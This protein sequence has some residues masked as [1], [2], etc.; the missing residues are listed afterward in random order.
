MI[1]NKMKYTMLILAAAV[2]FSCAD[3]NNDDP[4]RKTNAGYVAF[5]Y[6]SR[7][8]RNYASL[9]MQLDHFN[10]YL[11]QPTLTQRDSVDRLY[12]RDA[13]ILSD[14]DENK[15]RIISINT[16]AANPVIVIS[17]NGKSLNEQGCVWTISDFDGY[18]NLS[19][20]FEFDVENVGNGMWHISKHDNTSYDSFEYTAEWTVGMTGNGYVLEGS[21]TLLSL[22]SPKLRLDYLITEPVDVKKDGNGTVSSVS[23]KVRIHATDVDKLLTE[24]STVR[25]FSNDEIEVTYM[26]HTETWRYT[27]F[28]FF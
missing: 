2:A 25:I 6:A 15:W 3:G 18:Y 1:L 9:L 12:F 23:G 14:E 19:R 26:N 13:K 22:Q 24:E 17:T 8:L 21:G 11:I 27:T 4:N 7:S 10:S 28:F 5:D 20:H 16:L